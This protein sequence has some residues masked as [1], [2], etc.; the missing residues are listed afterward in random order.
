M[1][2]KTAPER[3]TVIVLKIA[4]GTDASEWEDC[5]KGEYICVGWEQ[6][7]D[8]RRFSS[9]GEF[10]TAFKRAFRRWYRRAPGAATAKANELWRLRELQ[11]G[12]KVI[13]NRGTSKVVAVGTVRETGCEWRK[14]RADCNHTVNVTW[15]KIWGRDTPKRIHPQPWN[16]TVAP[17]SGDLYRIIVGDRASKRLK[18]LSEENLIGDLKDQR[19]RVAGL[20]TQRPGQTLFRDHLLKAYRGRCALSNCNAPEALEAAHVWPSAG[21]NHPSNGILLRVDLHRLFDKC[22]L[23]IDPKT[24]RVILKPEL[25]TSN[26]ASLEGKRLPNLPRRPDLRPSEENLRQHYRFYLRT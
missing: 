18:I 21:S 12:D 15:Q 26:Y 2:R 11:D 10:L 25:R 23:T 13:A 9:K 7:G 6:V 8:L 20:V 22:L 17:V 4:P 16:N 14:G 24:H 19:K 1:K 5:E 3:Q